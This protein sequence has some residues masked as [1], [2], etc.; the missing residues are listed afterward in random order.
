LDMPGWLRTDLTT[1]LPQV[2]KRNQ[3]SLIDGELI[4]TPER[5][6]HWGP[7]GLW[8]APKGMEEEGRWLSFRMHYIQT[9]LVRAWESTAQMMSDY[10]SDY[11]YEEYYSTSD[12]SVW[13]VY[14]PSFFCS[15]NSGVIKYQPTGVEVWALRKERT[16]LKRVA[17]GP[18]SRDVIERCVMSGEDLHFAKPSQL[19]YVGRPIIKKA[20]KLTSWSDS[21][22]DWE[23]TEIQR[24]ERGYEM[25]MYGLYTNIGGTRFTTREI[26]ETE[27]CISK[28][29]V[30]ELE[31]I[32]KCMIRDILPTRPHYRETRPDGQHYYN[33]TPVDVSNY[34]LTASRLVH[35][36]RRHNRWLF[37][38]KNYALKQ[39]FFVPPDALPQQV[40]LII[41]SPDKGVEIGVYCE[42]FYSVGRQIRD[43]GMKFTDFKKGSIERFI[44][45]TDSETKPESARVKKILGDLVYYTPEEDRPYGFSWQNNTAYRIR[46]NPKGYNFWIFVFMGEQLE[47]IHCARSA[48]I[49]I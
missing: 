14:N 26:K 12:T 42:E 33:E 49:G 35:K 30:K 20:K 8:K 38:M 34:Y 39:Y 32:L 17:H 13:A 2:M 43:L 6:E 3:L 45:T 22:E 37:M 25:R 36:A 40:D 4:W 27:L 11:T 10:P 7:Q 24:Q 19:A 47:I 48:R 18:I 31:L 46:F 29:K 1:V 16:E 9:S 23:I 5:F 41:C 15:W 21:F 28:L 44:A